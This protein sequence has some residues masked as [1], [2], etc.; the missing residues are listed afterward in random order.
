MLRVLPPGFFDRDAQVVACD[1]LGKLVRHRVE[2]LWRQ[3]RLI[4]VE[5]YY[6]QDRA[7]HASLGYTEK[8][9]ALF[10]PP[11]TLYLYYARG[12]DSLNVSCRG[13][14][15]A[16][17]IKAGQPWPLPPETAAER[18]GLEAMRDSNP[19]PTGE[20]R[21]VERLCSGQ[22][23]LCRAMGIKVPDWNGRALPQADL[24]FADARLAAEPVL[25]TQRLGI[26][27]GRDGHLPYR[28]VLASAAR[29]T[30][31]SPLG[32]GREEGRDYV[33]LEPPGP[34]ASPTRHWQRLLRQTEALEPTI[35]RTFATE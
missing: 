1:L 9:R 26:P 31:R 2:G 8:R 20:P 28:F 13:A 10:M 24:Q 35:G 3:V 29:L 33:R 12:G 32:R 17:L 5:A 11:G 25:R 19:L 34:G 4:E 27:V 15:N 7:S 16:V 22:T 21:P 30:T 6:L 14:G 23:L 18:H